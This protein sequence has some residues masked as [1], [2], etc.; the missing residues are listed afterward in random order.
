MKTYTD[1]KAELDR[2]SRFNMKLGDR[3]W[4]KATDDH[5]REKAQLRGPL[6]A[7][8]LVTVAPERDGDDGLR[9]LTADRIEGPAD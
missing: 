7:V 1:I 3:V 8:L 2:L 9:V 5:P 4:L 6:E